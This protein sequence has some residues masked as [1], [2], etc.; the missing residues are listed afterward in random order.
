[1]LLLGLPVVEVVLGSITEARVSM[2][3]VEW[4]VEAMVEA[5]LP[6]SCLPPE[7]CYRVDKGRRRVYSFGEK[8]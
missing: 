2:T 7:D 5:N 8:S 4:M 1:M 3:R 6:R